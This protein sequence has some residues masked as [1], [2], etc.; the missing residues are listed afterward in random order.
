MTRAQQGPPTKGSFDEQ[1]LSEPSA[2]ISLTLNSA[3]VHLL[4]E[5]IS[6]FKKKK[7]KAA[8]WSC[9]KATH[10]REIT[11]VQERPLAFQWDWRPPFSSAK[12]KPGPRVGTR[13]QFLNRLRV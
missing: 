6:E 12:Q 11:P 9:A 10:L 13:K 7:K 8:L 3:L 1:S 4:G 2:A 5:S